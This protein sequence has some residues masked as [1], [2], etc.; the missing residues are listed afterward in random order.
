M[1]PCF[2]C[3][4]RG[5]KSDATRLIAGTPMCERCFS[6]KPVKRKE[7][8]LDIER[9]KKVAPSKTLPIVAFHGRRKNTDDLQFLR[10]VMPVKHGPSHGMKH[11]TIRR[12]GH[13]PSQSVDPLYW[14]YS[15]RLHDLFIR[16]ACSTPE[17]FSPKDI[18]LMIETDKAD[19]LA[20]GVAEHLPERLRVLH[21]VR[22]G[23]TNSFE[24]MG[25]TGLP[26]KHV[27]AWLSVLY[28]SGEIERTGQTRMDKMGRETFLYQIAQPQRE[29][30][31]G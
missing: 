2:P 16:V 9:R 24:V 19:R 1:N 14:Q 21:S 31:A 3:S 22:L 10:L 29:E 15:L 4:D 23:A 6:G 17:P 26:H 8:M 27:S 5:R 18:T 11:K 12:F 20:V 7:T 28:Q 13:H 25:M 30:M